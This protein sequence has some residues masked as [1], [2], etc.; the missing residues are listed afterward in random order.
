MIL[1]IDEVGR[2]AWA[3]PLV[4]GACVLPDDISIDHLT[5]SKRLTKNSRLKLEP[6]IKQSALAFGLGWVSSS[7]IDAIGLSQALRLAT[8]RAVAEVDAK[9]YDRIIIDGT[10]DF[11]NSSLV[12]VMKQADLYVPSV[13]AAA[14]LAKVA[15]D[16]MMSELDCDEKYACY[17]FSN[18]VGY[19]TKLHREKLGQY[20]ACDLHRFSFRPIAQLQS[21][22]SLK[23]SPIGKLG[24]N[25]AESWLVERDYKILSRNWRTK[26]FEVDIVVEKDGLIGLIEVK[27]RQTD[28]FGGGK[29]AIDRKKLWHLRQ[30][31]QVILQ[32]PEFAN[33]RVGIGIMSVYGRS[34]QDLVV[35]DLLW[36]DSADLS[37]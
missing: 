7:E 27:T 22:S 28:Y 18:H 26:F 30:A 14:I 33:H 16:R 6:I 17:Q 23:S 24:E 37:A 34:A 29:S 12:T 11:L 9:A 13:S 20:G 25:L 15:R 32:K 4:V 21:E 35:D 2:G 5:D 1:G 3:G 36:L 31:S 19:G 8:Q 10:V